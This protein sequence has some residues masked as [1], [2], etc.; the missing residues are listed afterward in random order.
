MFLKERGGSLI[1]QIKMKKVL[2]LGK[3]GMLGH[4]VSDY[5]F[6]LG[7]YEVVSI[8]KEEIDVLKMSDQD[9]E[10]VLTKYSPDYVINAMGLISKSPLLNEENAKR[11]NSDFP[12]FLAYLGMKHHWKLIHVSTDCYLDED[13]YGKS[14]FF[15]EVND[16]H[17]LTIRTSI[18]GPELNPQGF[19]L[20]NWFMNQKDSANGFTKAYWD[21]VTTLQFA[22]FVDFCISEDNISGIVDYRTKDSLDKHNLLLLIANVFSKEITIQQDDRD[23]KDKRNLK[24]DFWCEKDYGLQLKE[25]KEYMENNIIYKRYF[26]LL[27]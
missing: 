7:K 16:N 1:I 11:L 27:D 18:I 15:G 5:L 23:M 4:M 6:S 8:D 20:F 24:A 9:I 17:N 25:L 13:V 3:N 10:S 14:K 19:G 2:V 22:K 26:S 21:G 12:H